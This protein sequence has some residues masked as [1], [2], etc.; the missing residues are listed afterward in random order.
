MDN[1]L[2]VKEAANISNITYQ[3]MIVLV[4]QGAIPSDKK[5]RDYFVSRKDLD[6]WLNK[7]RQ[8]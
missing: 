7:K 8:G 3:D 6:E 4:R 1:F 5:G 2:T